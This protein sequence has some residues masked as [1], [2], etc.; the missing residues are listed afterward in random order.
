[1]KKVHTENAPKA[2]GPYSQAQV[3]HD[4]LVFV[5]GQIGI[6]PKTGEMAGTD[7]VSQ[8]EQI[9]K[10]IG[11][12]LKAAGTSLDNVLKATCFLKD[13]KDFKAFNEVYAKY[14]VNTPARSC[15]EVSALPRPGAVCEIEVY[16]E[17]PGGCKHE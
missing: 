9:C 17:I 2:I 12:I 11:E 7:V 5:S 10:N 15:I 14:F 13:I 8:A 3:F 1:M 6:D 4:R 16:A